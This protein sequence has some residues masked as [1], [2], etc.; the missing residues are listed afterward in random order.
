MV[1][2][3]VPIHIAVGRSTLL[4]FGENHDSYKY[5]GNDNIDSYIFFSFIQNLQWARNYEMCWKYIS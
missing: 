5:N 4:S 1:N 2:R 3:G